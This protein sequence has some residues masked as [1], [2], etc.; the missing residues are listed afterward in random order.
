MTTSMPRNPGIVAIVPR[1]VLTPEQTAAAATGR[2]V[3]PD[4]GQR[5]F[6]FRVP[7]IEAFTPV[8]RRIQVASLAF[9][10]AA[11]RTRDASGKAAAALKNPL[12]SAEPEIADAMRAAGE[13]AAAVEALVSEVR[14][15]MERYLIA[16]PGYQ[17]QREIPRLPELGN[18]EL[19]QLFA[20]FVAAAFP[21]MRQLEPREAATAV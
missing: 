5:H 2:P 21:Y 16:S 14:G 17:R 15:A 1:S 12:A 18:E 3:D 11:E 13:F 8:N 4:A 20:D 19:S 10:T 7:S 6:V 9:F